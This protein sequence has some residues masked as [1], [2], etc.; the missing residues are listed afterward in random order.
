MTK[1]K[2]ILTS[3]ARTIQERRQFT[4]FVL[5]VVDKKKAIVKNLILI[6]LRLC[7]TKGKEILVNITRTIEE[8]RHFTFFC[9]GRS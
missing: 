5:E 4:F 6:F 9:V 2:E 1:Q 7:M 3:I 8:R